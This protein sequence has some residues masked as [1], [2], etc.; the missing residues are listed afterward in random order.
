MIVTFPSLPATR[1]PAIPARR[2]VVVIGAD[3]AGLSAALHLGEHCLLIEQRLRIGTP[4]TGQPAQGGSDDR[5]NTFP[6]GVAG[7]GIG[8]SQEVGADRQRPG[9]HAWE[10]HAVARACSSAPR[11]VGEAGEDSEVV[12]ARW[13]APDLRPG[14]GAAA[15][16]ERAACESL[17]ILVASLR[18]ELRLGSRVSRIVASKHIVELSDGTAIVYDKLVCG[19]SAADLVFLLQ[20]ELPNRIRSHHALMYWLEARDVELI[21][22]ATQFACGDANPF[23]AG[24][25]V[26]ATVKRALAQKFRPAAETFVR[27]ETLFKP[28]LVGATDASA[29]VR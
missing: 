3:A 4:T 8:C 9:V 16:S 6:L 23:A 22:G 21:D 24:R 27:R 1:M 10:R 14:A 28:R 19:V 15:A 29:A 20:P 2:R 18:G 12:I 7:A 25:R 26:A 17:E 11:Q 13:I 5:S